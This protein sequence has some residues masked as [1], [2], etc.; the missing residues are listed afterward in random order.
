MKRQGRVVK[1]GGREVLE[2]EECKSWEG[3]YREGEGK[4]LKRNA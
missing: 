3:Q 1:R 2:R 4:V